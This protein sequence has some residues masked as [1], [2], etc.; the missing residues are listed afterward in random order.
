MKDSE[1]LQWI[2]DRLINVHK[3]NELY[4]Y[5]YRL[6][7]IISKLEKQSFSITSRFVEHDG[8]KYEL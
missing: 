3:E 8:E 5:M 4:D 2:Y 1:F 6:R 7:E